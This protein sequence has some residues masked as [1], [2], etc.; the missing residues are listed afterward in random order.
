MKNNEKKEPIICLEDGK[1]FRLRADVMRFYNP[2]SERPR[3]YQSLCKALHLGQ[4]NKYHKRFFMWMSDYK[5]FES[6]EAAYNFKQAIAIERNEKAHPVKKISES[7]MYFLLD[8]AGIERDL[9]RE[10]IRKM[11]EKKL[12]TTRGRPMKKR[13]NT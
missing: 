2:C 13:A 4:P 5:K 12:L 1:V 6:L 7:K 11:H 9:K 3:E 8:E 10:I